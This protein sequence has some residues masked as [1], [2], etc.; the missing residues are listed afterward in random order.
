MPRLWQ[1]IHSFFACG[2][3]SR[4]ALPA[5]VPVVALV[6][7]EQDRQVLASVSDQEPFDVHFAES[8]EVARAVANQLTAPIVLLDRDW[9]GAEWRTAV[10]RLAA[11]PHCACVILMSGVSDDYLLQELIRWGGYDILPKPLRADKAARVVKLALSY[12]NSAP[13]PAAPRRGS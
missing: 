13:K 7:N 12:W 5:R 11:A 6:V 2:I 4:M 1:A 3:P 9:P 10:E 8:Y